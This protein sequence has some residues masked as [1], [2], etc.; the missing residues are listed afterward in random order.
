[1]VT[2]ENQK[3]QKVKRKKMKIIIMQSA[4]STLDYNSADLLM[5]LCIGVTK[6]DTVLQKL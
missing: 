2:A 4:I 1:M 5:H 3:V 6:T